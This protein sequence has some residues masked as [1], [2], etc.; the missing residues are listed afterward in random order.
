MPASGSHGPTPS[1]SVTMILGAAEKIPH[2]AASPSP[3][4]E[5]SGADDAARG[6]RGGSG[7]SRRCS[8]IAQVTFPGSAPYLVT[9]TVGDSNGNQATA[10]VTIALS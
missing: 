4:P 7:G 6:R 9:L 5:R 2:S 1:L 10:Q 8:E 3:Q